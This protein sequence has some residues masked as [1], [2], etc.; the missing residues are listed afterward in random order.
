MCKPV[1]KAAGNMYYQARIK[2]AELD[3]ILKSRSGAAELLCINETTLAKYETNRLNVSSMMA[4][5]MADVYGA[6]ELLNNYCCSQCP[7]GAQLYEVVDI[8]NLESVALRSASCFLSAN[9]VKDKFIEI[10]A[11]GIIDESEQPVFEEIIQYF[12]RIKALATEID[13]WAKRQNIKKAPL[14]AHR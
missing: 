3:P 8:Q 7:I 13:L 2:A 9:E 4:V 6:P 10:A 5:Q 11:D 1:S 14:R 12:E